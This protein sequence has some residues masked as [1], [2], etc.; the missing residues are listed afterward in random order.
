MKEKVSLHLKMS[1]APHADA[2]QPAPKAPAAPGAA[3]SSAGP[4]NSS[5]HGAHKLQLGVGVEE[6]ACNTLTRA[7][8]VGASP[9]ADVT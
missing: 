3:A 5:R 1:S 8:H 2:P 4:P 7:H 9:H 6:A